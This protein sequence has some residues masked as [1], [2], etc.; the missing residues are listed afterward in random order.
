MAQIWARA[1]SVA[2][3]CFALASFATTCE[4]K[5]G[6]AA[7]PC[8]SISGTFTPAERIKDC[9]A[10]IQSGRWRGRQLAVFYNNRGTVYLREA[11]DDLALA[12][13]DRAIAYDPKSVPALI[14]RA[15]M[16]ER[17]NKFDQAIAGYEE[18]LALN[19]RFAP[20]F[21]GRARAYF[22]AKEYDRAVA[23][24]DE[25]LKLDPKLALALVGRG[26][27]Y[28]E[29]KKYER[30]VADFDAAL[31]IDPKLTVALLARACMYD[32]KKD[33]DRALEDIDKAL[34]IDPEST[35]A[36]MQRAL[37]HANHGD[38]RRAFD[39][40]GKA[41]Q[42]MYEPTSGDFNGTC[43]IRVLANVDL[44]KAVRECNRALD[45]ARPSSRPGILHSRAVA[46]LRRGEL[47]ASRA[48]FDE[49]LSFAR[50]DDEHLRANLFYGRGLVKLRMGDPAGGEADKAAALALEPDIAEDYTRHNIK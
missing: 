49:G 10:E 31:R 12:D 48:D 44:D 14:N 47:A 2:M 39:D 18:A 3:G 1:L 41:Q 45:L 43:W 33:H 36:L 38:Y 4:A 15:N 16:Y 9:T 28:G 5:N 37:V 13:Y 34:V 23:D 20:T 42:L 29:K 24:F 50:H 21:Y 25:A 46:F 27:A 35:E 22:H 6:K 17:K 32:G 11:E 30:A 8:S 26:A 40:A 19:R 7:P